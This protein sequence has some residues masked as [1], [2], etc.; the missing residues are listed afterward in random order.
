MD[1]IASTDMTTA[2]RGAGRVWR[3]LALAAGLALG[4]C[5]EATPSRPPSL[6]D[7]EETVDDA[8]GVTDSGAPRDARVG[9]ASADRGGVVVSV[10]DVGFPDVSGNNDLGGGLTDN[11]VVASADGGEP[12]ADSNVGPTD[13]GGPVGPADN[14]AVIGPAD[15]GP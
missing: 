2:R 6:T 15:L 8:L 3:A 9:D 10:G 12:V 14:G 13:L 1:A 5:V 11:G 7:V 4:G